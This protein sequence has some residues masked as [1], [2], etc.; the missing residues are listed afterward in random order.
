MTPA[1]ERKGLFRLAW[2][3][4]LLTAL[5]IGAAFVDTLILSAHSPEAA[6]AVSLGNLV[7]EV[8]YELSAFLGVGTL[9]LI[10]QRLGRG[11]TGGAG[12]IAAIA[13]AANT[14]L[15]GALA[16]LLLA[17][18]PWLAALVKTPAELLPDT[19]AYIRII[20]VAM[21]FNGFLTAAAAVLRGF[22][23]TVEILLLGI[24]GNALYLFLEYALLHGRFG[25]PEMGVQGAALAT[26]AVRAAG[27]ILMIAVLRRR[28]GLFRGSPLRVLSLLRNRAVTAKLL[29]LSLPTVANNVTANIHQLLIVSLIAVLGTSAV[30]TRSY[31]LTLSSLISLVLVAVSQG[32]ETLIGYDKGAGDHLA[33][34][35][36]ATRTALWTAAATTAF[37]ALLWLFSP[38]L[39]ALF[40]RDQ[41]IAEGIRTLLLIGILIQPFSAAAAICHDSLRSAGDVVIPVLYQLAAAWLLALPLA[42]W[43]VEKSGLGV[44][45]LWLALLAAESFKC[46][47]L[48]TRWRRM[49][50]AGEIVDGR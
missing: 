4:L 36:R 34:R 39:I 3:L 41:A 30:L 27:V 12:N 6:A 35:R 23:R 16:L 17:C 32:N 45:G 5:S 8:S 46:A 18:A 40:T 24:V 33:A 43:L 50:W 31:T 14:L 26:L 29:R 2:P 49:R 19:V 47:V 7:L 9:V 38:P 20:G 13:I 37:A 42:W 48:F 1:F 28:L 11:D 25:L 21:M 44:T 15:G 10:A 22:G